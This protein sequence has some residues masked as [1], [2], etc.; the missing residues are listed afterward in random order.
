MSIKYQTKVYYCLFYK[1]DRPEKKFLSTT[2]SFIKLLSTFS[3]CCFHLT[4]GKINV[5]ESQKKISKEDDIVYSRY[6]DCTV[7]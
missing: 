1:Q 5:V 3:S 6:F 2:S 7:F 4:K